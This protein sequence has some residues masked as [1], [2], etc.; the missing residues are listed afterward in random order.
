VQ[1]WG[2]GTIFAL[3][4]LFVVS[5]LYG[6]LKDKKQFNDINDASSKKK[7]YQEFRAKMKDKMLT[8]TELT[9]GLLFK[10]IMAY[11]NDFYTIRIYKDF[12]FLRS[13]RMLVFFLRLYVVIMFCF[14]KMQDSLDSK[15]AEY[16]KNRD[17]SVRDYR[18][19]IFLWSGE[20]ATAVIQSLYWAVPVSIVMI[21]CPRLAEWLFRYDEGALRFKYNTIVISN[22]TNIF[23]AE[24]G[25]KTKALKLNDDLH[26]NI[27]KLRKNI[28]FDATN[29]D[30]KFAV[31][32]DS[33]EI[34]QYHIEE[35]KIKADAQKLRGYLNFNKMVN[36]ILF[37]SRYKLFLNDRSDNLPE[38][39]APIYHQ[40][41]EGQIERYESRMFQIRQEL[42]TESAHAKAKPK[43]VNVYK[44]KKKLKGNWEN[45]FKGRDLNMHD[46]Y[47]ICIYKY[48]KTRHSKH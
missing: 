47:N 26:K 32:P 27:V 35:V 48:I 39:L 2:R 25:M 21:L 6:F 11:S 29:N 19:N 12:Y 14:Y 30:N 22:L 7:Y 28:Q 40:R 34:D 16:V 18:K 44:D 42:H 38:D 8:Y 23:F 5:V 20:Y 13:H 33:D 37:Q 15:T 36:S 17:I 4:G 3:G 45:L 10:N 1:P 43:H 24:Q 41:L 46:I 31:K 9:F